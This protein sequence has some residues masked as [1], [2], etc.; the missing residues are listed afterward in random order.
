MLVVK[1]LSFSQLI[2][3]CVWKSWLCLFNKRLTLGHGNQFMYLMVSPRKKHKGYLQTHHWEAPLVFLQ[4]N[5]PPNVFTF[6]VHDS[7]VWATDNGG[8]HTCK[9]GYYWLLERH[10]NWDKGF[11]WN[12]LWK[13]KIPAKIQ[14]F[15]IPMPK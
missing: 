14:Y 12:W 3:G 7:W 15:L 8:M 6:T 10:R 11:D 5:P 2:N 9:S 4:H 1:A 13:L